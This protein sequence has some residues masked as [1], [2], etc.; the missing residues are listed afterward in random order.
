MIVV[1]RALL[2][3]TA[4]SLLVACTP[5]APSPPE[6]PRLST[7]MQ[8]AKPPIA[9][10]SSSAA[11]PPGAILFE[12]DGPGVAEIVSYG[13]GGIASHTKNVQLPWTTTVMTTPG[14]P[15][16]ATLQAQLPPGVT[17]TVSCRISRDGKELDKETGQQGALCIVMFEW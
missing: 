7:S 12:I 14:K 4:A 15:I 2:A 13:T 9:S 10:T 16:D 3:L 11:A 6:E 5:D 17:G 1:V 8:T